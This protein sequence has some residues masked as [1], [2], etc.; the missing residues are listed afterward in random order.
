MDACI[1]ST[2]WIVFEIKV[3]RRTCKIPMRRHTLLP[4]HPCVAVDQREGYVRPSRNRGPP[5][6]WVAVSEG[7][8]GDKARHTDRTEAVL[9]T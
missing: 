4:A 9:L 8:V 1:D 2:Q 5:T 3:P 6:A 7:W